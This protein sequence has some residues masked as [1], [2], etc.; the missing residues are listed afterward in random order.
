MTA[1]VASTSAPRVAVATPAPSFLGMV[2]G[3]MFKI[4]R[5]RLVWIMTLAMAAFVT[6]PYLLYLTRPNLKADITSDPLGGLYNLMEIDLSVLR[7]FSGIFLLVLAALVIGLEYQQ[8]T[9]RILLGRGVGR[10]Q[11]LG[12]KMLALVTVA[13]GLIVGTLL[14]DG[15]L[16]VFLLLTQVGNLNA[17]QAASSQFWADS[18][19]YFLAV[20]ISI[21]ATLLLGVSVSVVGRSLAFGLGVGLSW[22]AADNIGVIVMQLANVFTHQAF[23]NDITGFFLGPILNTL[24]RYM[25]PARVMT[26]QSASGVHT[27]SQP[28]HSVGFSPLVNI[29]ATHAL[30]VILGYCVVFATVA[31]VLTWRRDVLE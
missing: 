21:G 4:A 20:L 25:V 24:P 7:V 11:L 27:I 8:G 6:A 29:D 13:V 5:L 16:A 14:L 17:L 18:R 1:S 28:A 15:I 23:W 22:F 12:A 26:V 3:E 9:I 31:I 2:G 19:L 30:L 10:L